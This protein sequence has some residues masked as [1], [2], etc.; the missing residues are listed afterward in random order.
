VDD[1]EDDDGGGGGDGGDDE[2]RQRRVP[3]GSS[4]PAAGALRRHVRSLRPAEDRRRKP[5]PE[6]TTAQGAALPLFA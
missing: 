1:G 4:S 2:R 3:R 5:R 6:W